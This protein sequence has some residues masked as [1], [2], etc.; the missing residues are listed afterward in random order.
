M[1]NIVHAL[2]VFRKNSPP[3]F[4]VPE[5]LAYTILL[6]MKS[7]TILKHRQHCFP[8]RLRG[9]QRAPWMPSGTTHWCLLFR[10]PQGVISQELVQR[11][12]LQTAQT[13]TGRH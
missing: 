12:L 7:S 10:P 8:G 6:L 11:A 13:G 5:A 3:H 4:D 2:C 1:G 9:Y